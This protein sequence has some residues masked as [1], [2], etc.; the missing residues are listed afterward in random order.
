[1]AGPPKYGCGAK[2]I[3][4]ETSPAEIDRD[5]GSADSTQVATSVPPFV[6]DSFSASRIA[7]GSASSRL[8]KTSG[9]SMTQFSR[10]INWIGL[11]AAFALDGSSASSMSS[12]SGVTGNCSTK[13]AMIALPRSSSTGTKNL[14]FH[15]IVSLQRPSPLNVENIVGWAPHSSITASL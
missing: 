12:S 2:N 9:G 3:A 1:M 10:S 14:C 7:S 8:H 5:Q 6:G 13:A 4:G 15:D 11:L